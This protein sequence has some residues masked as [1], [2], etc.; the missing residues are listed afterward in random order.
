MTTVG[1]LTIVFLATHLAA[2]VAYHLGV[3]DRWL[4]IFETLSVVPKWHFFAPKPGTRDV[5]LLHRNTHS[6]GAVGVWRTISGMDAFRSPWSFAWNPDKRM[7]KTLYDAIVTLSSTPRE[8]S[9][10]QLL[11]QLSTPYLL[12]L[13][14]VASLA[15]T[16]DATGVQFAIMESEPGGQPRLVLASE[17]HSL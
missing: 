10:E 3:G 12:L 6:D 5:F 15:R 11:L 17:L 8:K 9:T 16:S 4:A 14:H 13:N 2:T 7:R 1:F